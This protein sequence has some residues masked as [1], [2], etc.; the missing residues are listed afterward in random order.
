[1]TFINLMTQKIVVARV[2]AVAGNR[3]TYS[4]ITSE[5]ASIHRISDL[6]AVGIGGQV[7]KTYRIYTD[8]GADIQKGDR[9]KDEDGYIYAVAGVTIPSSLGN[10]VHLEITAIKI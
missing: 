6:Q 5:Y 1:M 10:F 4:T 7:G 8:E 3:T 2:A 9:L